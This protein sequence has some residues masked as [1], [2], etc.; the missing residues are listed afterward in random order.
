MLGWL[1]DRQWPIQ[2]IKTNSCNP[3]TEITKCV[4]VSEKDALQ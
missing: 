2:A 3:I 1:R 4:K